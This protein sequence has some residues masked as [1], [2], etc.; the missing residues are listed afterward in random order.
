MELKGGMHSIRLDLLGF[1]H[2]LYEKRVATRKVTSS[3][4]STN[5]NQASRHQATYVSPHLPNRDTGRIPTFSLPSQP[6][7][8]LESASVQLASSRQPTQLQ[9]ARR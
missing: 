4:L 8:S 7:A 2:S 3:E 9:R 6:R 1:V 5:I